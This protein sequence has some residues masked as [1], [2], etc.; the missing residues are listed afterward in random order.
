MNVGLLAPLLAGFELFSQPLCRQGCP[1]LLPKLGRYCHQKAS[2]VPP[3]AGYHFLA[4]YW[5]PY[6]WYKSKHRDVLSSLCWSLETMAVCQKAHCHKAH[7]PRGSTWK[8]DAYRV[9]LSQHMIPVSG[10]QHWHKLFR[11]VYLLRQVLDTWPW[12]ALNS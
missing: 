12:L 6:S 2:S 11:C 8:E 4:V 3:G 9:V 1:E 5:C 10:V 7:L